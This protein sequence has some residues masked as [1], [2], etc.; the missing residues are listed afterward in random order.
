MA[1]K[2]NEYLETENV[3]L[4]KITRSGKRVDVCQTKFEA[5]YQTIKKV[6]KR[7]FHITQLCKSLKLVEAGH[8]KW[9]KIVSLQN[10]KNDY[11]V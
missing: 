5:E 3:A 11:V 10:R 6:S 9:V 4:K 7:G 2:R 8:Y 1:I